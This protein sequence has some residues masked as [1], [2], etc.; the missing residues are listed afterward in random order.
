MFF[1]STKFHKILLSCF[2]GVV[3]KNCFEQYLILVKFL[4]S[5]GGIT[6]RKKKFSGYAH[7]HIKS[8]ITTKFHEI[9]LNGFRGVALKTVSITQLNWLR[10]VCIMIYSQIHVNNYLSLLQ[11]NCKQNIP[12]RAC[13]NNAIDTFN[14]SSYRKPKLASESI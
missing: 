8:F 4:S 7:L 3:L 9:L 6:P 13:I 1:I 11:T 12:A 10:G 2:S 14:Q 5:K